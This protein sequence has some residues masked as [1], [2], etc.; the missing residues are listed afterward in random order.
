[1][2]PR[3]AGF[4]AL[5]IVVAGSV[6]AQ[7]IL[8]CPPS[9]SAVVRACDA[10]HFHVQMYRPDTRGFAELTGVNQFASQTACDHYRDAEI[11]RNA[12][13]VDYFKRVRGDQR[14]EADRFGP[15]HCDMTVEKTN[16]AYLNDLQRIAQVRLEEEV[17]LRVRERLLD[18]GV[19]T[20]NELVRGLMTPPPSLPVLGGAKMIP[21]P[22]PAPE[23]SVTNSPDDLKSTK[24]IDTSKPVVATI[25]DLP[26]V[27]LP[28]PAAPLPPETAAVPQTATPPAAAPVSA[29][30]AAVASVPAATTPPAGTAPAAAPPVTADTGSALQ[31][32]VAPAPA[33]QA[34][35]TL[36]AAEAAESFVS[37]ETQRIQSVLKASAVISDEAV[38]SKIFEA[39]M[40]RIQL[41]SNLRSLIEGSGSRSRLASAARSAQSEN[42]R[43]ALVAKLFGDT[44]APEWAP[45]DAADVVLKPN[46]DVDAEPER[47]LRDNTGRFNDEQKKR[48]L[49]I[50][51]AR[52]QPTDEQQLWLVTVVDSFLQ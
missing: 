51:L 31:A 27:D 16:A 37:Y 5:L 9:S 42:D 44:I 4:L 38:K 41:L 50:M 8:V 49:Y 18:A 20:D 26:L 45:K 52:S 3:T 2:L 28:A 7:S 1:M 11:K 35:D 29:A 48:A 24:A 13:V 14:Y 43:L 30:P 23:S 40:Q 10:F 17:R 15:C 39:C 6:S 25:D 33:P 46:A 36:S 34:A 47:V 32:P 12:T 19:T 21:V 22:P